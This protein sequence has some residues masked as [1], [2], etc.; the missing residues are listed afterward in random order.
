L[1]AADIA[2]Q[3]AAQVFIA[4]CCGVSAAPAGTMSAAESITAAK[5]VRMKLLPRNEPNVTFCVH[6]R[7]FK[8]DSFK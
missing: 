3:F 6:R 8:P 5:K 2:L 1:S 7:R 4:V